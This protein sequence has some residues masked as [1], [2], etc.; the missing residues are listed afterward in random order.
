M[1][2]PTP[3]SKGKIER[4][5]DYWQKRLPPILAADQIHDL[6]TANELLESLLFHANEHEVHRELGI[7]PQAAKLRCINDSSSVIRPVPPCPWWP[8]VWSQQTRVRVDDQGN[9]PGDKQLHPIDAPPRSFV[10]RCKRFDGDLFYLRH[11]PDSLQK[12]QVLLH[13]PVF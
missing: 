8:Y 2:A 11:A 5:H 7:T 9:V 13:F 1:F 12:P 4:R 10:I 3:Q 6:A